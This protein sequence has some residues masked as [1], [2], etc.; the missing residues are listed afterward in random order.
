MLSEMSCIQFDRWYER[1]KQAPWG[2]EIENWR[3]GMICSVI[4]NS[5]LTPKKPYTPT[6][7]YP[8]TQAQAETYKSADEQLA[9]W[10]AMA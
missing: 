5:L 1:F 10:K 6:D 7:F 2:F 9:L 4:A 3:T 8:Q